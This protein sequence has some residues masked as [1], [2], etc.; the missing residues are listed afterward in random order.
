MIITIGG[1]LGAGKTTLAG[2]LAAAL[3]YE[4][5]YVGGIFREMAAE[6]RLSIEEFYAQIKNDP[7]LEREVDQQQAKTMYEHDNLVVQGRVAWHFAKG[8]PF[9]IFNIFLAVEPETG[10]RRTAERKENVGRP[11]DEMIVATSDR[12]KMERARYVALYDIADYFDPQHYDFILDT[13][14]LTE[15]EVLA[16][17]MVKIR[18]QL[19]D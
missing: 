3:G 9:K 12:E 8:S 19:Q 16:N 1:N 10:A 15:D 14:N 13:S 18:Q 17:A 11:M 2:K 4:E 7:A 6:K 5:L